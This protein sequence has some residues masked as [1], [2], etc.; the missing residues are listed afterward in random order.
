MSS[1]L[2]LTRFMVYVLY[3]EHHPSGAYSK[4]TRWTFTFSILPSMMK[5]LISL[6]GTTRMSSELT[7]TR[8]MVYS[9]YTEHHPSRAYGKSTNCT[10]TFSVFPS[11]TKNLIS[12]LGTTRM[13]SELTPTRFMV[14]SDYTEHHPSRAYGKSTNCTFT[15]S[16]FSSITK[17]LI[18]LL[19]TT[20]M[21]SEL[22]LTRF[23][24][25]SDYTEHHPS[26]AYSKS[27]NCTFTFSV[28]SSMMKN[29][30]SP[31]RATRMSSESLLIGITIYEHYTEHHPS[32]AYSKSTRWTF[33]FSIL[34]S[35]MKNLISPPSIGQLEW[36]RNLS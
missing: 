2:T 21:S 19:G 27:T 5:N 32:R 33:T 36:P 18:S 24:V 20:R 28:F 6:L 30:I 15:F 7:P 31:P 22:T 26:G 34:P 12:L 29:L 8:F 14:Y 13:S 11:I 35:M 9:D 1:E 17:N 4:S 23:M 16:V 3:T 25:Y 10:F